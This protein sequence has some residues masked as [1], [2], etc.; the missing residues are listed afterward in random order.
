[1]LERGNS[2]SKTFGSHS[3]MKLAEKFHFADIQKALEKLK[4]S[5]IPGRK[6]KDNS[7]LTNRDIEG[8][9]GEHGF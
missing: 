9:G 8:D 2:G 7:G 6:N 1:M 3:F 4:K 5:V